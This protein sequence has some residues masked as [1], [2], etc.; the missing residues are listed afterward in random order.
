VRCDCLFLVGVYRRMS[1]SRLLLGTFSL[2]VMVMLI[3]NPKAFAANA[4][5]EI[6]AIER[7][8]LAATSVDEA[9]R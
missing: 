4:K 8:C 1:K 6:I 5:A 9:M 2:T 3:S 7:K